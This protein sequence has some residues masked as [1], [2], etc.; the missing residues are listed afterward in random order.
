[1]KRRIDRRRRRRKRRKHL[2][3]GSRLLKPRCFSPPVRV[4][5]CEATTTADARSVTRPIPFPP[6]RLPHRQSRLH[7]L[8]VNRPE[9]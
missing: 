6:P 9:A 4:E 3:L 5:E 7:Q 8:A 2:A 1:M